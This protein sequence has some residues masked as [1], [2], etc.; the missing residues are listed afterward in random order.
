MKNRIIFTVTSGRS[1]TSYL[2][3]LLGLLKNI[4][5]FHESEPNF[6]KVMR[7]SQGDSTFAK[8]FLIE[9]KIPKILKVKNKSIY[10]ETSHLFCKGFLENWLAIENNIVPDIILLDRDIREVSLS[11]LKLNTIPGKTSEGLKW[12]LSPSDK[13]NLTRLPNWEN[14]SDYQLCYWYCLEIE[15]RKKTYKSIITKK[16]GQVIQIN[17][18]DLSKLY[19]F[20]K[21]RKEFNLPNFS[22]F[23]FLKY[24]KNSNKKLNKKKGNKIQITLDYNNLEILEQEVKNN[25]NIQ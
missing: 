19:K 4:N 25:I 5:C 23:G 18:N 20:N 1:G 11:L 14:Y 16:G 10:V 17:I 3:Y 7:Q 6:V 21:F 24:V 8:K 2:A 9:E 22:F 12:Y 15:E 13:Y